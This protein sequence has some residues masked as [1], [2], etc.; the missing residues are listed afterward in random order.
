MLNKDGTNFNVFW[1][2]TVPGKNNYSGDSA[3]NRKQFM[4]LNWIDW[5]TKVR[6]ASAMPC[7]IHQFPKLKQHHAIIVLGWETAW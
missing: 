2:D 7:W 5:T 4:M 1:Y 6:L 3:N